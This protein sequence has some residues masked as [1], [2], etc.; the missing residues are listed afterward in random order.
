VVDENRRCHASRRN[1]CC[2]SRAP[3]LQRTRGVGSD[4]FLL[5]LGR[6]PQ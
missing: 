3:W 1:A 5:L 6:L 4:T 2:S